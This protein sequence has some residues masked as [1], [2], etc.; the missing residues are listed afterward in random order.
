MKTIAVSILISAAVAAHAADS[1]NADDIITKVLER[2]AARQSV[3]SVSSYT[4]TYVLDN[5]SRHAAM[6]VRW[7]RGADGVKH[8]VVISE[9]GDGGVRS[10]VFHKLLEA[11]VE[12]S[13]PDQQA[14]ARVNHE[15]Y[16][17]ELTGTENIDGRS[18]YVIELQPKTGARYLTRGRI[19]V[20]ALDYAVVRV[21]GAPAKTVSLWTKNVNFLQSFQKAGELWVPASNHSLTDARL[22][23]LADLT[24]AY[25]DY[26]LRPSF[27]GTVLASARE[28]H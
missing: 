1:P 20:D 19:W 24:I 14:K 18:T 21:E 4:S 22:F 17:F 3:S 16:S 8:F 25:S 12:A 2:D 26:Q 13:R 15:N 9:T 27:T 23:G 6:T 5:K 10:H 28:G 11:E 7:S